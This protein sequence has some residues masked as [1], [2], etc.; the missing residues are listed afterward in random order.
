LVQ[1]LGTTTLQLAGIMMN[2]ADKILGHK[3]SAMGLVTVGQLVWQ[4]RPQQ[5]L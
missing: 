2:F 4:L 5:V 1:A 3:L